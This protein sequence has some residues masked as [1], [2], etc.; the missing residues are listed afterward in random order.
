MSGVK[1]TTTFASSLINSQIP[2]ISLPLRTNWWNFFSVFQDLP[3][4]G[5]EIF[6]I[7][8]VFSLII[9][10][11]YGTDHY[12]FLGKLSKLLHFKPSHLIKWYASLCFFSM[13]KFYFL[14]NIFHVTN[15]FISFFMT[16]CFWIYYPKGIFMKWQMRTIKI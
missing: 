16:K 7:S 11:E 6:K 13:V 10:W 2:R 12:I 5:L 9:I 8:S 1:P 15:N 4:F 14:K 3:V